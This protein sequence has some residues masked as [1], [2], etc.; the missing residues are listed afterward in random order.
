MLGKDTG[1]LTLPVIELTME[2]D[3]FPNFPLSFQKSTLEDKA[4]KSIVSVYKYLPKNSQYLGFPFAKMQCGTS[5]TNKQ[6]SILDYDRSKWDSSLCHFL[7]LCVCA[8][9][10]KS[11]C[12]F[13]FICEV[14]L[15]MPIIKMILRIIR[16][17]EEKHLSQSL[18][19]DNRFHLLT[20]QYCNW[21]N[22]R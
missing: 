10:L 1:G 11:Q 3:I 20:S 17:N 14:G 18:M 15:I 5:K 21:K 9:D 19:H 2:Y 6:K 12:F 22:Q 16:D 8:H 4:N 13:C 7:T